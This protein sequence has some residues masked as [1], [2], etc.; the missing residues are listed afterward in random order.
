[1]LPRDVDVA[2]E[3]FL[4]A[5]CANNVDDRHSTSGCEFFLG[6]GAVTWPSRSQATVAL[7][8]MEAEYMVAAT[9]T[10]EAFWL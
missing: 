5:K 2:I 4:D 10:Q 1:M 8:T 6:G 9:V 7:S 3:S